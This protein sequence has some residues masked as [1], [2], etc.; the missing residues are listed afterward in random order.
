[1]WGK[2][3]LPSSVALIWRISIRIRALPSAQRDV[4]N[5]GFAV[6]DLE[7]QKIKMV[8]RL[9]NRRLGLK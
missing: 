8:S 3:V 1:M 5:L 6:L 2:G 9:Y 4:D 7:Q